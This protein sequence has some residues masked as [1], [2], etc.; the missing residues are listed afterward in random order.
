MT[1]Q[2]AKTLESW[3]SSKNKISYK[4]GSRYKQADPG[5]AKLGCLV[6]K[7]SF[8]CGNFIPQSCHLACLLAFTLALL[9]QRFG[10]AF[11]QGHADGT[12]IKPKPNFLI[13]QLVELPP[14]SFRLSL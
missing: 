7:L 6:P 12:C 3:S 14:D 1:I 5:E 9:K 8:Q 10:N 11:M 2:V 13:A 4:S